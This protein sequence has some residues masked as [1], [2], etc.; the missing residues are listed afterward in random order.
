M[1]RRDDIS[2]YHHDEVKRGAFARSDSR[3]QAQSDGRI[4]GSLRRDDF[5]SYHHD[6]RE[7]WRSGDSRK[8]SHSYHLDNE[9]QARKPAGTR[10]EE[11]V[12][13]QGHRGRLEDYAAGPRVEETVGVQGHRGRLEDNSSVVVR[14]KE[15]AP[16]TAARKKPCRR[17]KAYIIRRKLKRQKKGE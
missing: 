3:E 15:G 4:S 2:S 6:S 14:G 1:S 7:R 17:G 12:G 8:R 16:H 5:S 13:V 9:G 10:G 11:T